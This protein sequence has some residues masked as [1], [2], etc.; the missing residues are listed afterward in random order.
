L[1]KSGF[2]KSKAAGNLG[3]TRSTFRYK[4]SK[5]PK[6]MLKNVTTASK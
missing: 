3:L 2:N 5:V 1:Q 6:E 4:L